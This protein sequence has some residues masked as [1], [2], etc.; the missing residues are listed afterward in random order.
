MMIARSPKTENA[1]GLEMT[2]KK[3]G[4]QETEA[5]SKEEIS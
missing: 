5:P 4:I 2:K 1:Q 3:G